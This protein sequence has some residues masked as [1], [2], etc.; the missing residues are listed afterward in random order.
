MEFVLD[1][2]MTM[3]WFFEDEATVQ[4]DAALDIMA[5]SRAWVPS[6]WRYEVANVARSATLRK[7]CTAAQAAEKIQKLMEF[8]IQEH[9]PSDS[10]LQ[11]LEL[12]VTHVLS[13]YGTAYLALAQRLDLPLA[14]L[15]HKLIA[16]VKKAKINLL[17]K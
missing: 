4:S 3:S 6:I 17:I 12:S 13:A 1:C 14:T 9:A 5:V 2:S 11:L 16:A 7:R 8:D 15:D 10:P